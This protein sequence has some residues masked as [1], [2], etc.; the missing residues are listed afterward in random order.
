M[1]D[2]YEQFANSGEKNKWNK[3]GHR[4]LN[5]KLWLHAILC[6]QKSG[7]SLNEKKATAEFL[8]D[9]SSSS[10]EELL[11]RKLAAVSIECDELCHDTDYL[12]T[13]AA[14][15][16]YGG[17]VKQSGILFEKLQWVSMLASILGELA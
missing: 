5:E 11:Y 10:T 12:T 15:L 3:A 14:S 8:L 16:F 1:D 13:A 9:K 17:Q 4:L 7:H 6:F 2:K